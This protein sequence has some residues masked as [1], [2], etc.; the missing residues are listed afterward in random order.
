MYKSIRGLVISSAILYAVVLQHA[1]ADLA[2]L[3]ERL[4]EVQATL[5]QAELSKQLE[6]T[7]D[8][9]LTSYS[10]ELS[11]LFSQ[12]YVPMNVDGST[13]YPLKYTNPRIVDRVL[14]AYIGL[15]ERERAYIAALRRGDEP[16]DAGGASAEAVK[17]E[18][19]LDFYT[20]LGDMAESTLSESLYDYIWDYPHSSTFRRL[21]L[22]HV[23]PEKTVARLT[24]ADLGRMINGERVAPNSLVVE[25]DI[26]GTAV[27]KALSYL[28]GIAEIHPE[29]AQSKREELISLVEKHGMHYAPSG[30]EIYPG[31][32][33]Y[34]SRRAAMQMLAVAGTHED[35]PLLEK[36]AHDPPGPEKARRVADPEDLQALATSVEGR[37]R[38]R[39]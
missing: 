13:A 14:R 32:R 19:T 37:L 10:P 26:L 31:W 30:S 39:N 34:R 8:L 15:V 11:R 38:G 29:I 36:L 24:G 2:I 20:M 3:K 21:Y 23:L 9:D 18:A 7:R 1:Q 17:G 16:P 22:A 6:N 35:L 28:A 25:G 12:W 33:D 5:P 27:Y 4:G